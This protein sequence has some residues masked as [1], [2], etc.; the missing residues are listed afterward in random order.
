MRERVSDFLFSVGLWSRYPD[1]LVFHS[2]KWTAV[3]DFQCIQFPGVYRYVIDLGGASST[4]TTS[5]SQ[6][7]S[8]RTNISRICRS[9]CAIVRGVLSAPSFMWLASVVWQCRHGAFSPPA[10][11]RGSKDLGMCPGLD[12]AARLRREGPAF[13]IGQ[14]R[15]AAD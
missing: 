14:A 12:A 13:R 6:D 4:S 5:R 2:H 9:A 8:A 3:P 1:C 11:R 10:S 15:S 7:C